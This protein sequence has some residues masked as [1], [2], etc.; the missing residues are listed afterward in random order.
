[1]RLWSL[2]PRHL[3][4]AGLVA[5]WRE[6]LLAQAVLKGDTRG[7]RHHPQLKR[8]LAQADPEGAVAVYLAAV[9][10]EAERRGYRFDGAKI[11]PRRTA[12]PLPVTT[13]QIAYERE[14]LLE[15]L[16]RRDPAAGRALARYAE[17]EV[18]PLFRVVAGG[19]EDWERGNLPQAKAMPC[20]GEAT[21]DPS[22]NGQTGP[23]SSIV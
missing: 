15:K 21:P 7:Y 20:G 12:I 5:L 23:T 22:H 16:R 19:I 6:A 17:P 9:H 11:G 2:H 18:H 3:D 14:H 8:F 1:M 13:G 4:R 10:R